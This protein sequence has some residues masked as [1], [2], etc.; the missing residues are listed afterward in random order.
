MS[1]SDC[2]LSSQSRS[3]IPCSEMSPKK[4]A[5]IYP[6]PGMISH[7]V[8]TVELGKLLAAQGLDITIVLGGHDEKEAAATATTS[9]L[10]EAAAANPELSFHRLPQPTLQ[11]DVPAD[12][13]VSRIFE[14]ARSSGPDLRDFLRSTSPAVLIIDFFCY[15]A[16]NIGAELGIPTYFFLTTCIASVAFMLYLPV[17]QGENTLSFRDLGGDLVHAPGIPP[18]PADHLP[19]SQ[20]D[21]DSMSSN[22][23]LALSEQV[24]NA[25]GVMVNSCR[26]LERRAADAVVAGLCTF[27]GRRTPPLHCIGPL[28]KPREDDSAERHECLAWLD[29]QPKDSVLFLCFGSMGVFSVE[30]IKQVAV[31]LETSGHRFLWVVRRPPGFEHVTGPDL[32]ALIFPEGF[33]RRTKGR[34]LVVMSWAPQREV[35]EHGAVGGFVTH[36]GWNSVLEAVTAGVPMLAWPLYAEQRMNKVFLV[37]EMRLAVA[38]EGYDKGVVTAEEIQEKARWIMDSD[39]GRELRERTLAAMREVKEALSDKG[40]FKIALLQL[41]SQWKN[42]N[43]S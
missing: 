26:S 39:G 4:L 18:I 9:F 21:R 29:A 24:C 23:F 36:C 12:D 16:L 34:G 22:H 15:S 42:Y 40:E 2:S 35:L 6:P 14:F 8:S 28:I 1:A 30:Q 32:E 33:L 3:P 43:N 27:P 5:V 10:A 37:E 25:H 41:T 20:F 7:L 13:Y 38:V 31:G 17:V 19:R 11:C